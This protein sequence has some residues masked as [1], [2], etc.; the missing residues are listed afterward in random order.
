VDIRTNP[1]KAGSPQYQR[2]LT[3]SLTNASDDTLLLTRAAFGGLKRIYLP[4]YACHKAGVALLD[5][6]HCSKAQMDLF[7]ITKDNRGR[8]LL[9]FHAGFAT[10]SSQCVKRAALASSRPTLLLHRISCWQRSGYVPAHAAGEKYGRLK[11]QAHSVSPT[12]ET[13]ELS[14]ERS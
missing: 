3:I 5:L 11:G 1:Y 4:G 7:S 8:T 13:I 2:G 10:E 6:G 14:T 9:A 12:F